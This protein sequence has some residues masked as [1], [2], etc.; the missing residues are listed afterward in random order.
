MVA[1]ERGKNS[2]VQ[3]R[4][5]GPILPAES[6]HSI[7]SA[8]ATAFPDRSQASSDATIGRA[9]IR[10]RATIRFSNSMLGV[11]DPASL[12]IVC[13]VFVPVKLF[14]QQ[15]FVQQ[16]LAMRDASPVGAVS[17]ESEPCVRIASAIAPRDDDSNQT[18]S[19]LTI[20][21]PTIP[22]NQTSCRSRGSCLSTKVKMQRG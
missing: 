17:L 15:L 19:A 9:G 21:P 8:F 3:A 7:C 13:S 14:V 2:P 6:A 12:N 11:C 20:T 10:G 22:P 4:A 18:G 16:K 1:D 5:R